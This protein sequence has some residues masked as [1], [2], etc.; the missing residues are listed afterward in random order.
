MAGE[1]QMRHQV[2]IDPIAY[3]N[4]IQQS[5]GE[6]TVARDRYTRP[7]MGWFSDRSTAIWPQGGR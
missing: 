2:S 5:R 6:F 4:Y 7:R 1:M 3:R